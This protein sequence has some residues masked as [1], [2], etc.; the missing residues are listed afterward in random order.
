VFFHRG[1][2]VDGDRV[3]VNLQRMLEQHG[4]GGLLANI[5][6]LTIGTEQDRFVVSLRGRV[7]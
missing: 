4:Q 3:Y 1:I 6:H 2:A 5:E 7:P